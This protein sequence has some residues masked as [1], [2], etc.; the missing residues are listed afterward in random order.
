VVGSIILS[1]MMPIMTL[2][3][4]LGDTL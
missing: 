3:Q 4:S 1:V 2:Y